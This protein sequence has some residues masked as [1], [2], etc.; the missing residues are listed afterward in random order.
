M[1]S[2][3]YIM[4]LSQIHIL[5]ENPKQ[6]LNTSECNNS[7]LVQVVRQLKNQMLLQSAFEGLVMFNSL[8][9]SCTKFMMKVCSSN[10][11]DFM[12]CDCTSHFWLLHSAE[13]CWFSSICSVMCSRR[14]FCSLCSAKNSEH[15]ASQ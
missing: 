11:Q 7:S 9:F 5:S 15:C 6:K 1:R 13:C 8:D 12:N 2:S 4:C 3:L 10:E 14:D